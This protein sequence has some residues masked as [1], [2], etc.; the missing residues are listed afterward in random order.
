MSNEE[1]SNSNFHF[2]WESQTNV[3][4][5]RVSGSLTVEGCYYVN[6]W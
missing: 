4:V 2:K 1:D 5:S 3:K 6:L